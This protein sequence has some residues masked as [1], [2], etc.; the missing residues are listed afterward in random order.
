MIVEYGSILNIEI[1]AGSIIFH[2]KLL[3][4]TNLQH[5][6]FLIRNQRKHLQVFVPATLRQ[7]QLAVIMCKTKKL[8]AS[9]EILSQVHVVVHTSTN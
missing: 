9:L 6:M 3:T 1:D 5:A 8:G 4:G 7:I 2:K